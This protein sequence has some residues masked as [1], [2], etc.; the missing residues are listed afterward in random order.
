MLLWQEFAKWYQKPRRPIYLFG[1]L[2][3]AGAAHLLKDAKMVEPLI[4]LSNTLM[5]ALNAIDPF[6]IAGIFYAGMTGC[7]LPADGNI[8][9]VSCP[10]FSAG[11]LLPGNV[12]ANLLYTCMATI[13][14]ISRDSDLGTLFLLACIG[15]GMYAVYWYQT[16]GY[17]EASAWQSFM[18]ILLGPAV[19]AGIAF[20][21]KVFLICCLA[22][23]SAV[24]GSIAWV[25]GIVKVIHFIYKIVKGADDLEKNVHRGRKLRDWLMKK[26][27]VPQ[28]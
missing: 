25:I 9:D 22:I 19:G 28:K 27:S 18:V 12:F 1:G 24:L 2:G 15:L 14:Q 23:F 21:A 16:G 5:A 8:F 10:T 17:G 26:P 13:E 20:L 7:A 6:R 3:L 4:A 11:A